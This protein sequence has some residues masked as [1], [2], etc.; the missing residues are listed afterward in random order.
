M[1][2]LIIGTQPPLKVAPP[3]AF[4]AEAGAGRPCSRAAS[5]ALIPAGTRDSRLVDGLVLTDGTTDYV[6]KRRGLNRHLP[7]GTRAT[8]DGKALTVAHSIDVPDTFREKVRYW[9]LMLQIMLISTV[10]KLR[11]RG[12]GF[13]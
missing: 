13:V 1:S 12:N 5:D 9:A 3:Q 4:P 6:V 11:G 10:S 2:Q 7:E 8:L